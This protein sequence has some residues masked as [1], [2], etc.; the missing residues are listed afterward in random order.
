MDRPQNL[1]VPA[2]LLQN[3]ANYLLVTEQVF[4]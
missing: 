4:H 3:F 1:I 2:K